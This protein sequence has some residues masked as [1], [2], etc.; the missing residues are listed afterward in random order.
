VGANGRL[1]GYSGGLARK[2]WLL[3]HEARYVDANAH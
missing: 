2:E 3:A 1:T